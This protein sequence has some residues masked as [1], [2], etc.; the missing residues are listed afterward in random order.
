MS[1]RRRPLQSD[2]EQE[3]SSSANVIRQYAIQTPGGATDNNFVR[4]NGSVSGEGSYYAAEGSLISASITQFTFTSGNVASS[5][6]DMSL[7]VGFSFGGGTEGANKSI[8]ALR[9]EASLT[10]NNVGTTTSF[11]I[12]VSLD[13]GGRREYNHRLYSWSAT[14]QVSF[15][16]GSTDSTAIR[17]VFGPGGSDYAVSPNA[18]RALAVKPNGTLYSAAPVLP[19]FYGPS[20][21]IRI[22]AIQTPDG[23]IPDATFDSIDYT[24]RFY[25]QEV[26]K[27]NNTAL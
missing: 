26:T 27:S 9:A 3:T 19:G 5:V 25:G 17:G 12:G 24:F 4:Q 2:A 8:A 11:T 14:R 15:A 18:D 22:T 23:G 1:Q 16:Q 6:P 10:F 21:Q 13:A 7:P 20:D